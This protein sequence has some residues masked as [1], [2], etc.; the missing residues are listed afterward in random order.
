[1]NILVVTNMYPSE[2]DASWRGS[3]VKEQVDACREL[4]KNNNS[5]EL[6]LDVFHIKSRVCGGS[7]FNYITSFF[8]LFVKI[9][10]GQYHLVHCH[11][12]FCVLV[13]AW[14]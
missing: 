11:H 2:G 1:M 9:L 8:K 3:F 4:A 14:R 10:F 7:N 5:S 12:A 13:C 6:S